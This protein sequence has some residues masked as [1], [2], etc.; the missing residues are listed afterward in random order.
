MTSGSDSVNEMTG[1]FSQVLERWFP[2]ETTQP[3]EIRDLKEHLDAVMRMYQ[4][5]L[6]T[7]AEI[8]KEVDKRAKELSK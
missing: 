7:R 2:L 5:A 1:W 4:K 6:E 8:M 3:W